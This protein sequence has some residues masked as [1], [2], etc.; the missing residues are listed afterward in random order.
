M[1]VSAI[2]S[3]HNNARIVKLALT[4]LKQ[5][6]KMCY[7]EAWKTARS[8]W[9]YW[10]TR[11]RT[12]HWN[13]S[14][15]SSRQRRPGSG[16]HPACC[17]PRWQTQ[18]PE[19]PIGSRR[20]LHPR[21]KKP[22]HTVELKGMGKPPPTRVRRKECPAFGTKCNYCNKDHHFEKMYM[23]QS[24]LRALNTR[25]QYPTHSARSHQWIRTAP[26]EP[27]WTTTFLTSSQK[28]G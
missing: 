5:W 10:G 1:Q 23:E 20:R 2:A 12:W 4:T 19:A 3:S 15:G 21:T 9:I 26:R 28:R 7:A 22:E 17:Y 27:V 13:R 8:R 6:S 14:L 18:W 25:T 16:R 11:T 24:Q